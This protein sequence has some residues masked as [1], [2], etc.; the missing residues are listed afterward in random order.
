MNDY[1]KAAIGTKNQEYYLDH[2]KYFEDNPRFSISWNWAALFFNFF[3]LIYRKL[4]LLALLCLILP[5]PYGSL[6][7]FDYATQ[8]NLKDISTAYL[9]L[10]AVFLL[11]LVPML[12]NGIYYSHLKRK[13]KTINR[14]TEDE[15]RRLQKIAAAGGT[16][17]WLLGISLA[18]VIVSITALVSVIAIPA[19]EDRLRREII[20]NAMEA[21]TEYRAAVERY[22]TQNQRYPQTNLEANVPILVGNANIESILILEKGIVMMKLSGDRKLQGKSIKFIPSLQQGRLIGWRCFGL[23]IR[24]RYLPQNCTFQ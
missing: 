13:I 2:F 20:V 23:G 11:L 19:Y 22:F 4:Y 24:D 9:A 10:S 18:F 17:K 16:N 1:L 5:F 14:R 12:A 21:A 15:P 8:Y 3:W 6:L 7:A